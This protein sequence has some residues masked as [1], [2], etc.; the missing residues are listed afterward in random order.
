MIYNDIHL[1]NN[2]ITDIHNWLTNNFLSLNCLKTESLHIKIF[3]TIFLPPQIT[4]NNLSIYYANKVQNRGIL[5][6]PTLQFYIHTKL[7]SHSINY[8]LHNLRKIRPF[9][10]CNT[11]KLISTS[12]I[13]PTSITVIPVSMPLHNL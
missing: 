12:L 6:D 8:L 5:I 9:I 2:C 3:T 7:L 4:I 1:L 10:I 11:A 13:L